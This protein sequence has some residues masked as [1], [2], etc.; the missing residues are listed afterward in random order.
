MGRIGSL[1]A[2]VAVATGNALVEPNT[3]VC[4]AQVGGALG[5]LS[6]SCGTLVGRGPGRARLTLVV[7]HQLVLGTEFCFAGTRRLPGPGPITFENRRAVR[8]VETG[9]AQGFAS[10]LVR[11]V[12]ACVIERLDVVKGRDLCSAL[13]LRAGLKTPHTTVRARQQVR[14]AIVVT[15]FA[16]EGAGALRGLVAF[17]ERDGV[18]LLH[19]GGV[20]VNGAGAL[21][22]LTTRGQLIVAA[23]AEAPVGTRRVDAFLRGV[24]R[25][26]QR[27]GALV[28]VHTCPPV[29]F[30]AGAATAGVGTDIVVADAIERAIVFVLRVLIRAL[31]DVV[32]EDTVTPEALVAGA[33]ETLRQV[34]AGRP[35]RM[36]VVKAVRTLVTGLAIACLP[37]AFVA[38]V[39]GAHEASRTVEAVRVFVTVVCSLD[40]LIDVNARLAIA[41]VSRLARAVETA[42]LIM[43]VGK[44]ATVRQPR[45][46]LV[47]VGARKPVA[48]VSRLALA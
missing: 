30:E 44:L 28:D 10:R 7:F 1:V 8:G 12:T 34:S 6:R 29:T 15:R 25:V 31:V 40:A 11:R 41:N 46:A 36:A 3:F 20:P 13:G 43:A 24:A 19:L 39:A 16:R 38:P 27:V 5:V 33:V 21:L 35:L 32:T 45:C 48:R 47:D 9:Q 42:G 22:G 37:A 4:C 18:Q 17:L 26:G 14:F 2:D 23:R